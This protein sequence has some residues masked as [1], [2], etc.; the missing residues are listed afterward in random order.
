[1]LSSDLMNILKREMKSS[2]NIENDTILVNVYCPRFFFFIIFF[3][4]REEEIYK[5]DK[6]IDLIF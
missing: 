5:M 4:G 2:F 1:V 3:L 6:N